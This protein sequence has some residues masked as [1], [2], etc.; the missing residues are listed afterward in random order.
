MGAAQKDWARRARVRLK[1]TLGS[2]CS[3][4]ARKEP[5]VVLV[6]DCIKPCGDAHHRMDTSQRMSFYHQQHEE[7]NLQLLC[8]GCNTEKSI[9][10]Q[11]IVETNPF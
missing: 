10:E 4:C 5:E 8:D 7:K 1:I 11:P 3:K 2:Q 6:F 9:S